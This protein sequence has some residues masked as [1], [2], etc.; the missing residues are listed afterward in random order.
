M[1]GTTGSRILAISGVRH[2]GGRRTQ[3]LTVTWQGVLTLTAWDLVAKHGL[4]VGLL[5][6]G[7]L[8]AVAGQQSV[9]VD[10]LGSFHGG[11]RA[12]QFVE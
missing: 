8:N 10:S 4:C 11:R 7:L 6:V 9:G 3:V 1:S 2:T 5:G 12:A